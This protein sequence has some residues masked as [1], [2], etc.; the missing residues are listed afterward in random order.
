M[1][2]DPQREGALQN[3]HS[4][5]GTS[6]TARLLLPNGRCHI[7]LP[8]P[9]KKSFLEAAGSQITLAILSTVFVGDNVCHIFCKITIIIIIIIII[10][11]YI[12]HDRTHTCTMKIQ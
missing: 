2:P 5:S 3:G 12:R 11:R 4:F 7:K 9:H 1:G 6:V 8:L 10:F